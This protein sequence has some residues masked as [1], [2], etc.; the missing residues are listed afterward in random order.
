MESTEIGQCYRDQGS[1]RMADRTGYAKG[2]ITKVAKRM[3]NNR[4]TLNRLLNP[5]NNAVTLLIL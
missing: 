1:G 3:R 2:N 5:A 4:A